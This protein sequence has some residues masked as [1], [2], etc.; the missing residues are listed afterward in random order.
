MMEDC[1]A[2][3]TAAKYWLHL[4]S[5]APLL[6]WT[7]RD[8]VRCLRSQ[9]LLCDCDGRSLLLRNLPLYMCLIAA[10]ECLAISSAIST[11]RR[12]VSDLSEP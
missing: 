2:H 12:S 6:D 10:A 7:P 5:S 1:G 3:A 11:T 8:G 9:A 4:C